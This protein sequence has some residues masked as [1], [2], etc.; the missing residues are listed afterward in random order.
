M[1]EMA[2]GD[3]T[4]NHGRKVQKYLVSW[5]MMVGGEQLG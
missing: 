3:K 4:P 2:N 1:M 5:M